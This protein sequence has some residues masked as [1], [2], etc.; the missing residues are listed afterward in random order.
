M[1]QIQ[2]LG[3]HV[4]KIEVQKASE[5][6]RIQLAKLSREGSTIHWFNLQKESTKEISWENFKD[7]LVARFGFGRLDNL[8]E[9]LKEMRQKGTVEEYILEFEL[10]S[11]QC[12]KLHE[13]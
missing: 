6:A 8:Y 3:L 10:Y 11:S 12:E 1:E 9:E 13:L 7:A 2:W 4:Q 5:K